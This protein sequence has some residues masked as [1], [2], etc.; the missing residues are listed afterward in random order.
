MQ[1]VNPVPRVAHPEWLWKKIRE[2]Y[3]KY[4]QKSIKDMFQRKQL[5]ETAESE[6]VPEDM[7]DVGILKSAIR[8]GPQPS[9]RS[10]G[11]KNGKENLQNDSPGGECEMSDAEALV[12]SSKQKS[13]G[14]GEIRKRLRYFFP[15]AE[16]DTLKLYRIIY[17]IF[18]A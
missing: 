5:M 8:N 10:Y 3:D 14:T 7:E 9:V 11:R 2:K 1:V 16:L 17:R 12:D 15:E 18:S 13:D 6:T 4:Q